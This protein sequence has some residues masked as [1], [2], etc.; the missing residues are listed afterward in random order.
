MSNIPSNPSSHA[1]VYER[2]DRSRRDSR[3]LSQVVPMTS[4]VHQ[5][6]LPRTMTDIPTTFIGGGPIIHQPP[7]GIRQRPVTPA[8][9]APAAPSTSFVNVPGLVHSP[10]YSPE[11]PVV[12]RRSPHPRA[13]ATRV[14]E[15]DSEPIPF[16]GVS[17]AHIDIV[18]EDPEDEPVEGV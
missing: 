10:N 15:F 1:V 13:S 12:Y 14:A 17:G 2:R 5:T 3:L 8:P 18:P 7:A 6:P 4:P 16:T 11:N 9:A